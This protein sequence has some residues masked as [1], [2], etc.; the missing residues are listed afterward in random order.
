MKTLNGIPIL[1]CG[2]FPLKGEEA[3][4]TVRMAI[5]LGIHH[6]DTAQMYGNE[7]DVGRAIR[8]CGVP[9]KNSTLSQKLIPGNLSG[10]PVRRVRGPFNG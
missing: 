6:I 1:G 8:D 5:D 7:A 10:G 3:Y 2:T 9:G 4:R